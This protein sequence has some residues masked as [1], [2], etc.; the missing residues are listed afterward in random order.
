M[1]P[2]LHLSVA[3]EMAKPAPARQTETAYVAA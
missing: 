3:C 1:L 2:L